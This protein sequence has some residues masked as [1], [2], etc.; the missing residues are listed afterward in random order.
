MINVPF[1]ELMDTL[2][3]IDRVPCVAMGCM[4]WVVM[5]CQAILQ[6][7]LRLDREAA[8]EAEVAGGKWSYRRNSS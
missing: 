1:R 4:M 7:K 8:Q 2:A 3:D 6:E 5:G